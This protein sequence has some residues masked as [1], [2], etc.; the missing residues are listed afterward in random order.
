MDRLN[1]EEN[2]PIPKI[3]KVGLWILIC[4]LIY[5]LALVLV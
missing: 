3:S 5:F 1:Q 2:P 4:Y